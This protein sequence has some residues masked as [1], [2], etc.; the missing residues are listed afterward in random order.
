MA[1]VT[2]S[3]DSD[4]P[5]PIALTYFMRCVAVYAAAEKLLARGPA[6]VIQDALD[7]LRS[8]GSVDSVTDTAYQVLL[9]HALGRHEEARPLQKRLDA[10]GFQPVFFKTLSNI[11]TGRHTPDG[12]IRKVAVL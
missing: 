5:D 2:Q 11:L 8:H 6:M 4:S 3:L 9:L 7:L 1:N 12:S 10:A